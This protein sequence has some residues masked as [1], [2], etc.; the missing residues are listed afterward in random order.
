MMIRVRCLREATNLNFR[1]H[2]DPRIPS[3]TW[4]HRLPCVRPCRRSGRPG[5]MRSIRCWH[6]FR[7]QHGRHLRRRNPVRPT[8]WAPLRRCLISPPPTSRRTSPPKAAWPKQPSR[9]RRSGRRRRKR[10]CRRPASAG[11]SRGPRLRRSIAAHAQDLARRESPRHGRA[12][13]TGRDRAR[14]AR[15]R[16]TQAANIIGRPDVDPAPPSG[17]VFPR[18][19]RPGLGARTRTRRTA[20]QR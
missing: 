14:V 6:S 11:S 4:E 18:T 12:P 1:R 5:P 13:G 9:A 20:A 15:T 2:H 7:L 17:G 10:R 8:G 19:T 16:L 3:P